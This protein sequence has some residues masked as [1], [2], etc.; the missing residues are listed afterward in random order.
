MMPKYILGISAFYHDSAACLICN[1]DIV[2]AAQEERFTRI[3]QDA[4]FPKNA[5]GYVLK[6]ASIG[7]SD[8]CAVVFYDKPFIK[9]ERL[10]ETYHYFAPRGI[11]SFVTSMPLW[12]KEKI[13]IKRNIWKGLEDINGGKLKKSDI[14]L[15]FPEHH[16]SHSA[17][18]FYPSPFEDAAI[19]TIDG[20]GEKN[21]ISVL[22]ELPFP[23]SIGLLYSSFTSYCGFKVNSGEYK[24]MGLAPYANPEDEEV[25]KFKQLIL[26]NLVDLK[27]DGSILLNMEYFSYATD[28]KMCHENKWKEL[29][30][31]EKRESESEISNSYMSLAQAIQQVTNEI[32][33]RLAQTAKQITGKNNLV[34]AGG[35]A[36][37]CV[38]NGVLLREK[39]FEKIWIQP[40]PGDAGGALGAAYAAWYIYYENERVNH[41]EEDQMKGSFLGPQFDSVE[42]EKTCS[43]FDAKYE[44]YTDFKNLCQDVSQLLTKGNVVGWFQGRMEWGP[45]A[46][47]NRSILADAREIDM[48]KKI[49]LKIKYR[50][51]IRPFSP[52]V[53][54]EDRLDY[55]EIDTTSPYM[56]LV[57]PV[58]KNR[59]CVK[60]SD[61]DEFDLLKKLYIARSD[62][63]AVTHIDYSARVQTV[64]K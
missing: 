11:K 1:G 56:L 43:K 32:V 28:L 26:N 9:F 13:F 25:K 14:K 64:D 18:A 51:M 23:H 27:D 37:N 3:K 19:L 36:L 44:R 12:I 46:L 42:I 15:L 4:S 30:G 58:K 33:L 20:V 48:Q 2:A 34:L 63:P 45:R 40:A 52:S 8:V 7:I 53:L 50:K 54:V 41:G 38:A 24:L 5:I 21:K 59:C 6:E 10:L 29:F 16:L 61:Y 17:S 22:K 31:I 60:P 49:N 39:I 35:V 55:F 62:I 47:G 57:A